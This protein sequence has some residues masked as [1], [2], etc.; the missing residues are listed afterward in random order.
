MKNKFLNI[1]LLFAILTMSIACNPKKEETVEP[2]IV[3]DKERIKSEIQAIEDRFALVYNDKNAELA[4]SYYA[5]DAV[6]YYHRQLPISDKETRSN[7][8]I[9]ELENF[10]KGA[11]ITFETIEVL[12]SNDGMHVL[13]IGRYHLSD[14]IGTKYRDGK[15][16]SYFEKRNGKYISIRDMNN[17]DSE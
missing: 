6:S 8:I 1:G 3:V 13:E 4:N 7:F 12:P 15:Y 17:Y 10:P 14:S 2:P 16:F 5:E 9:D 11:K